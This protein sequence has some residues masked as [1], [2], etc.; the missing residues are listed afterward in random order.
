MIDLVLGLSLAVFLSLVVVF[1]DYL[2]K[3]ASLQSGFSG[4]YLLAIG[5]IVYALTAVGWF[6]VMRHAKLSTLGVIYG[7]TC[8]IAL[9]LLSVFYFKETLNGFEIF[10]IILALISIVILAR[11]A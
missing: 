1:G 10:G 4:W 9:T 5:A 6:F 2:I 11:F 8:I 7:M 3:I